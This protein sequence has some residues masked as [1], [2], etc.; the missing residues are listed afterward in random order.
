MKRALTTFGISMAM[1][2][3]ASAQSPECIDATP[4][5]PNQPLNAI[6]FFKL[7][8]PMFDNVGG[9][10]D[11]LELISC[12]IVLDGNVYA[13]A[14][15]TP[16]EYIEVASPTT[17]KKHVQAYAYCSGPAGDSDPTSTYTAHVRQESPGKPVMKP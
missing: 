4:A 2:I 9:A 15:L 1:A 11:P 10:L 8:A 5:D 14:N 3:S 6:E 12:S 17:G 13:T 7:C 16:G